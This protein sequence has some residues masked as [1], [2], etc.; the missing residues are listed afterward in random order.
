[1]NLSFSY[2]YAI[3]WL[4]SM[5]SYLRWLAAPPFLWTKI[6]ENQFSTLVLYRFFESAS[7]GNHLHWIRPIPYIP[8]Y[9]LRIYFFLLPFFF[10]SQLLF[11]VFE[12]L[13][14]ASKI[15]TNIKYPITKCMES[16]V[17]YCLSKPS[18]KWTSIAVC[19]TIKKVVQKLFLKKID[20]F[21][22]VTA[23]YSYKL[24]ILLG[25]QI[26]NSNRKR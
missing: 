25:R 24:S 2:S 26:S 17:R 12:L 20:I 10:L 15:F 13:K 6:I 19:W 22:D 16:V 14:I 8:D 9:F 23:F 3:V 1:M 4:S 5:T 11:Q 18:F 7:T 21:I